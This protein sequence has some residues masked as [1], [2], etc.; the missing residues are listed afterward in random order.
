MVVAELVTNSYGHAFPNGK[1]GTIVVSLL[2]S[3]PDDT[4]TLIVK[5]SGIGFDGVPERKR[6]GLGLVR[7]LM[8]KVNGSIEIRSDGGTTSILK[9]PTHVGPRRTRPSRLGLNR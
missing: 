3:T 9:F 6:H 2:H 5:D 7:Q 1:R 4:A 8:E